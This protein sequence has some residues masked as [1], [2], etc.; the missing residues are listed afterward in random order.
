MARAEGT[1]P[2]RF[3]D[4]DRLDLARENNRHLSFGWGSHFCFG[5]PLARLEAR[6]TFEVLLERYQ[7]ITLL[8]QPLR[9]RENLGLRGLMAL[10]VSLN[11]TPVAEHTQV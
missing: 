10:P 3:P 8:P 7:K 11:G 4:P 9:W 1:C 5:A 6:V 2:L